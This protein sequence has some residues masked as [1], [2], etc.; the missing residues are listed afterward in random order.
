[1]AVSKNRALQIIILGTVICVCG[2][3]FAR[4][5]NPKAGFLASLPYMKTVLSQAHCPSPRLLDCSCFKELDGTCTP[6]VAR[7]GVTIQFPLRA[8]LLLG[9]AFIAFGAYKRLERAP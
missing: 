1:M 7:K 6:K 9:V 3:L 4:G 2:I 8:V 5:Y